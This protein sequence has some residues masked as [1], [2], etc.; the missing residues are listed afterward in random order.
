M[1]DNGMNIEFVDYEV[2]AKALND[3]QQDPDK[4][5]IL[6]SMTAYM[7]TGHGKKVTALPFESHYTTQILARMGFFWNA[8]N[9]KYV[10]DFINVLQG[11]RFF[12]KDNMNR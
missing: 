7:N 12:E 5:A 11:F 9:E 1:N 2:F 4:A 6:S 3:A 10:D 8:S